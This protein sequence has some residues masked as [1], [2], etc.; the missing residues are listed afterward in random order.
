MSNSWIVAFLLIGCKRPVD[1]QRLDARI[2]TQNLLERCRTDPRA[3]WDPV[4]N[5]AIAATTDDQAREC[6]DRGVRE[7]VH[8]TGSDDHQG[9]NPLLDPRFDEQK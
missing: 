1:L 6:I 9:I 2:V 3:Q 5:C 4:L 7:S 8:G